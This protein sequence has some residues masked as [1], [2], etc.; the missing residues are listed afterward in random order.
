MHWNQISSFCILRLSK[1]W[2]SNLNHLLNVCRKMNN[3]GSFQSQRK[4]QTGPEIVSHKNHNFGNHFPD[5]NH[6]R[7]MLNFSCEKFQ[8]FDFIACDQ[9]LLLLT[10]YVKP[11]LAGTR[12]PPSSSSYLESNSFDFS[13]LESCHSWSLCKYM[14]LSPSSTVL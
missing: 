6:N 10:F 11:Y 2:N 14:S 3:N 4:N 8:I 12:I 9:K 13:V 7:R 5:M 1:Q